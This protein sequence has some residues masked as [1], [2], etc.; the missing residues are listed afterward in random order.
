MRNLSEIYTTDR[1]YQAKFQLRPFIEEI[2]LFIKE[3][4]ANR[5]NCFINKEEDFKYGR[6]YYLSDQ[7]FAQALGKKLKHKFKGSITTT[8]TLHSFDRKHGKQ[9][10]RLTVCFRMDQQNKTL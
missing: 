9:V 1:N 8:R 4:I 2:D 10:Y 3:E 6:D 5:K 7:K